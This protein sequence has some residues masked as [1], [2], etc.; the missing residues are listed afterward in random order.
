MYVSP[1]PVRPGAVVPAPGYETS[2][3]TLEQFDEYAA[4]LAHHDWFYDFSDDAN[5]WRSGQNKHREL[6]LKSQANPA[7]RNAWLAYISWTSEA[8]SKTAKA[9]RASAIA[10]I[11]QTIGD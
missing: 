6:A 3:V 11:R 7:Y 10:T 1:S 8:S 2:P 4:Q 5:V 9:S